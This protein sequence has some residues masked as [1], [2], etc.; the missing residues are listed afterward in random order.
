MAPPQST[1]TFAAPESNLNL[2]RLEH[3]VLGLWAHA[4]IEERSL[5]HN[6]QRPAFVFFDG[7]PFATGLPHYGHILPGTIKD[8]IPRYF[9]MK[10]YAVPRRFGWDCHGLPVENL[11]ESELNLHGKLDIEDYGIARFNAACRDS[12]QRYTRE[13]ETTVRR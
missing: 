6:P 5:E 13:W 3:D 2:P 12:V 11:V 1:S 4:S 9:A 8:L 7:P 10:G